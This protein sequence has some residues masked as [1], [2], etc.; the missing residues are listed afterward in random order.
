MT[1]VLLVC[2]ILV[3]TVFIVL[4]G[5]HRGIARRTWTLLL[6]GTRCAAGGTEEG[7]LIRW[8]LAAVWNERNAVV[9]QDFS[10]SLSC[11]PDRVCLEDV[12]ILVVA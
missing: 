8:R 3:L 12:I 4:I 10:S 1:S 5:T 7:R 6:I 11:A 9:A 2:S